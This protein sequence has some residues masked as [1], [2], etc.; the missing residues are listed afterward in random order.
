[1]GCISIKPV[2]DGLERDWQGG[3]VLQ[4]E[5]ENPAVRTFAQSVEFSNTPSFF[6][7]DASGALLRRWDRGAPALADLPK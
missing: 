2:V 6:L 5:M 7:F 1:M 3:R 4:L